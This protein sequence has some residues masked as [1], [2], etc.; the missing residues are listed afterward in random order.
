MVRE[1][2]LVKV[3]DF[4]LAKLSEPPA[5]AGEFGADTEA[6]T[7]ALVKTTRAW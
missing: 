4:G 5:V 7:R 6:E 3:L 2:G 1:D